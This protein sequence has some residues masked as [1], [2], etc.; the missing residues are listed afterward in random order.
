[1]YF[2]FSIIIAVT[3]ITIIAITALLW[4]WVHSAGTSVVL[5]NMPMGKSS[6]VLLDDQVDSMKPKNCPHN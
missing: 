1:M 6:I 2:K 3:C 4:W 5:D